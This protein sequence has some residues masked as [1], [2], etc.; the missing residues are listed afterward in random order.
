MRKQTLFER[1]ALRI[2]NFFKSE[3]QKKIDSDK[4]KDDMCK[5]VQKAKMCNQDCRHCAW[6]R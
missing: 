5:A 2:I 6:G 4:Y 1:I 3:R